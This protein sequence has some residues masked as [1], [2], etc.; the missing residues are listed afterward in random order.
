VHDVGKWDFSERVSGDGTDKWCMKRYTFQP[1]KTR[2]TP[3]KV[4]GC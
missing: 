3:E 1:I 2:S 4:L